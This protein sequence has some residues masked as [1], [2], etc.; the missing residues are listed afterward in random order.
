MMDPIEA[1]AAHRAAAA[2]AAERLERRQL[3]T[4]VLVRDMAAG[5][6]QPFDAAGMIAAVT[7]GLMRDGWSAADARLAV[8]RVRWEL[9]Q[10]VREGVLRRFGRHAASVEYVRVEA[11][12]PPVVTYPRPDQRHEEITR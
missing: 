2:A 6:A 3:E 1:G 5:L 9:G 12:P 7:A 8:G 11:E 4:T 10:L